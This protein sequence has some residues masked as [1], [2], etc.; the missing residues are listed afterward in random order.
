M[1][2]YTYKNGEYVEITEEEFDKIVKDQQQENTSSKIVKVTPYTYTQNK[3]S[4]DVSGIVNQALIDKQN[5]AKSE[6]D[7]KLAAINNEYYTSEADIQ[8]QK[9]KLLKDEYIDN[10]K[11][12]VNI[13]SNLAMQGLSGGAQESM[14]MSIDSKYQ[15]AR[16]EIIDYFTSK[17]N[18]LIAKRNEE[19]AK[20]NASYQSQLASINS[21]Y[22]TPAATTRSTKTYTPTPVA[23][24]INYE[25]FFGSFTA[26]STPIRKN[27]GL[28]K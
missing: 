5:A 23:P 19:I 15:S 2:S 21:A 16:N 17:L 24:V 28:R 12:K 7:S 4:Y 20:Q 25:D 22:A 10:Q 1:P 18:E 9:E 27:S 13:D 8:T 3:T 26:K 11:Q 14:Q 6:N